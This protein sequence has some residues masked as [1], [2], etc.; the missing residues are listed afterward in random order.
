MRLAGTSLW[1]ATGDANRWSTGHDVAEYR[2]GFLDIVTAIKRALKELGQ[3]TKADTK[4]VRKPAAD[5]LERSFAEEA[6][7]SNLRIR[8]RFTDLDKDRFRRGGFEYI[9][10]FFDNSLQELESAR[11]WSISG[12]TMGATRSNIP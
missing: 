7:A 4:A 6:R 8:K 1:R 5:I 10:K 9:A 2:S 3:N 12:R 11:D